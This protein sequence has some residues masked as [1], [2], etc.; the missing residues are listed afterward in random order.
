MNTHGWGSFW[1][2]I[3]GPNKHHMDSECPGSKLTFPSRPSTSPLQGPPVL[4]GGA[5]GSKPDPLVSS[6]SELVSPQA[7]SILG[8]QH[9]PLPDSHHVLS[10]S[11]SSFQF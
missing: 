7:S 2:D 11:S 3:S 5:G 1:D 8:S 10:P 4:S 6:G 9:Q